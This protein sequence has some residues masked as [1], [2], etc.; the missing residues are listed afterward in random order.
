[1]SGKIKFND[2]PIIK[3]KFKD[4]LKKKIVLT[5]SLPVAIFTRPNKN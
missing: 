2:M 1:M 3:T 4:H 5:E